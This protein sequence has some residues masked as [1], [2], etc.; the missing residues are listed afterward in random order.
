ML[1]LPQLADNMP[2]D[3]M[4]EFV[5]GDMMEF[6]P[7]ADVVLLKVVSYSYLIYLCD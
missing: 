7:P 2:A 5:A 1:E 6:I 3:G 4:V